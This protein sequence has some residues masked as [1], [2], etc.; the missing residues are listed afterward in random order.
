[1]NA[2][3]SII[4]S[5]DR[6]LYSGDLI[7]FIMVDSRNPLKHRYNGLMSGCNYRP[8]AVHF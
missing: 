4:L 6:D 3:L 2:W 8:C 1:L 5:L 7:Y